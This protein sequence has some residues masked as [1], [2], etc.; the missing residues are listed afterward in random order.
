[1]KTIKESASL[2]KVTGAHR[3][4]ARLVAAGVGSS[5]VHTEEALRNTGPAAWPIGTQIHA[6][7]DSWEENYD[8]PEGSVRRLV[9]AVVSTP[10]YLSESETDVPGLYANVEFSNEWAPFVEQFKDVIGLSISASAYGSKVDA[11]GRDIF[12]GYIPSPLNRVD[13]VTVPGAQGRVLEALESYREKSGMISAVESANNGKDEGMT[14]EELQKAVVE[15]ITPFFDSLKESLKPAEVEPTEVDLAGVAEAVVAAD[16]PKAARAKVYEAIKSGTDAA[17]A[18]A[19]EQAYIKDVAES[20]RVAG[21]GEGHVKESGAGAPKTSG[22]I[23][24]PGWSI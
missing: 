8:R 10:E 6:D 1:M 7:H 14:P 16:L 20:V 17:E 19:A 15:A 18:I 2:G 11:Q 21:S 5:G 13:L 24:I 12:E 23:D 4:F 22:R 3:W 9:G